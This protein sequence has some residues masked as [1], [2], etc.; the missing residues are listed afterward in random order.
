VKRDKTGGSG[1]LMGWIGFGSFL[2][3]KTR[4]ERWPQF[5]IFLFFFRFS[6][7]GSTSKNLIQS[8]QA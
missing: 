3:K 1:G 5:S 2:H 8:I 4:R 6:T 7:K